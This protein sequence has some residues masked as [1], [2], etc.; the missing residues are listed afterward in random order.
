MQRTSTM[1]A[2]YSTSSAEYI[3]SNIKRY[4]SYALIGL[5][6]VSIAVIAGGYG[7]YRLAFAH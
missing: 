7:L 4:K 5:A 3:V 6:L 1:Q 2:A